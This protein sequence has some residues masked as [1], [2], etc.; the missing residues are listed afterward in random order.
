MDVRSPSSEAT[1]L[2]LRGEKTGLFVFSRHFWHEAEVLSSMRL[3]TA[4]KSSGSNSKL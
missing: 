2:F 4:Q 3:E 1:L